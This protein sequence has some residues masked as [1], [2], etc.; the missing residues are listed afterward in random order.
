MN[1]Q[2][3]DLKIVKYMDEI[4]YLNTRLRERVFAEDFESQYHLCIQIARVSN[5]LK[6]YQIAKSNSK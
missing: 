5:E 1:K 6:E 4:Q 3:I 2:N